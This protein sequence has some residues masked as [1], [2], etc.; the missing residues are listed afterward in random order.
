MNIEKYNIAKENLK[1]RSKKINGI[2]SLIILA[3]Y[4][5]TIIFLIIKKVP[6]EV[7][8]IISTIELIFCIAITLVITSVLSSVLLSDEKDDLN[9][10]YIKVKGE[11]VQKV[12]KKYFTNI[13][14]NSTQGLTEN[15]IQKEGL[16]STGDM[17]F[18][19]DRIT[20]TYKDI[21]FCQS[22]IRIK[23]AHQEVDND[24]NTRTYY[25]TVFEGRWLV[26]DFNKEFKSNLIVESGY[27]SNI[28][29]DEDYEVIQT[30]SKD[31]N[32][33]YEVYAQDEHEAFYILTPSF[34][35]KIT[36]IES[37]LKCAGIRFL[38]HNNKLH[39]G[40]NNSDDA[41]EFDELKEINEQEIEANMENDIRLIMDLIDELD[42]TNDLFKK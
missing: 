18:S 7:I 21:N 22:D 14:Y 41:F 32:N 17:F 36:N 11:L 8:L 33:S 24:G 23:E 25:E 6:F 12:L 10:L 28:I 37:K 30:E 26:F 38:F 2:T 40:I 31:F 4:L 13:T 19:N 9:K 15:F 42:I 3:I 35:E 5:I 20:G 16:L 39:I 1:K 29:S 27:F 34:M